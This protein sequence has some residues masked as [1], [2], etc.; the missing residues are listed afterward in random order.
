M[1]KPIYEM[2][3]DELVDFINFETKTYA[4]AVL[5]D[6]QIPEKHY[7]DEERFTDEALY[8]LFFACQVMYETSLGADSVNLL[9]DHTL[10]M[11]EPLQVEFRKRL[12]HP[13][14]YGASTAIKM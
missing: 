10:Q 9:D 4:Q 1:A 14:P 12:G 8:N 6:E 5:Q 2:G 13:D 11:Y 7:F 3:I